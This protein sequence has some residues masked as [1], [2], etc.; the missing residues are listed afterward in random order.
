MYP[1]LIKLMKHK[2]MTH[3]DLGDIIGTSQQVA[4]LRLRGVSDFRRSEMQRIKK[5]FEQ[6][7]PDVT[8]DRL[9]TTDIFLS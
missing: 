1:E 6:F 4:S 9:F 3:K 8:M 5:Y 7:Y 2:G